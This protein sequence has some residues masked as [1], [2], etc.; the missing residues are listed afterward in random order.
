MKNQFAQ[1]TAK[2]IPLPKNN[3]EK[4]SGNNSRPSILPTISKIME[5]IVYEQIQNYFCINDFNTAHQHAYRKGHSTATVLT[6]M[7]DDWLI[8]IDAGKIVGS[9]FIKLQCRF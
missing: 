2:I 5:R 3:K 8:E 7:T 9:V 4:F 1:Q 6:Q